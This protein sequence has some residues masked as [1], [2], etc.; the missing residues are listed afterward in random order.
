RNVL[1][2][3]RWVDV[4]CTVDAAVGPIGAKLTVELLDGARQ[5]AA[6]TRT[7]IVQSGVTT[8]RLA[9][10][11]VG[12]V[13]LW[14]PDQPRLYTLPATP[15]ASPATG[16]V[17]RRIGSRAESC[18]PDGSPLNGERLKIFGL[19]RHQLFPYAGMAA[20]ARLQRRDA[21]ILRYEL[22]C[23]MVRCSHYPQSPH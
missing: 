11:D 17:G 19:N 14:S 10:T 18:R 7:L 21:E 3:N 23:N 4:A 2:A 6:A 8:V 20:R 13:A 5:L 1:E 12:S 22:N 16:A 15:S 9:L